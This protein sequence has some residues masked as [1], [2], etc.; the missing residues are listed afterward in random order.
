MWACAHIGSPER[1]WLGRPS[2]QRGHPAGKCRAAFTRGERETMRDRT[3]TSLKKTMRA[4][5]AR[6]DEN[7]YMVLNATDNVWFETEIMTND[8]AHKL[9]DEFIQ[10]VKSRGHYLSASGQR[11]ETEDLELFIMS[12]YEFTKTPNLCPSCGKTSQEMGMDGSGWGFCN[13]DRIRWR[14]DG[15]VASDVPAAVQ[16]VVATR[17]RPYRVFQAG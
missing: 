11:I 6:Q 1:P 14:L 10:Q 17:I 9:A 8:E 15:P 13:R 5:T 4:Y 7:G 2:R 16:R 12:T 3:T